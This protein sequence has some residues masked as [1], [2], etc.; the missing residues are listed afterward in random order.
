L[1]E[2]GATLAA[3]LVADDLVD[4]VVLHTA[5]ALIGAEGAPVFGPL[6]LTQLSNASRWARQ[7]LRALG[8]DVETIWQRLP[9]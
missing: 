4:R 2:G 5:G 8:G 9:A 6:R 7:S 3:L 1:C